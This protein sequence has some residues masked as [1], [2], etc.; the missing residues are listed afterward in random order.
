MLRKLCGYKALKNVVL[1][2][3]MWGEVS[4]DIGEAHEEELSNK[5][6]KLALDNGA[7]MVRHNNDT[8][9]THHIIR[10]IMANLP[11]VLRIQRELVDERKHIS[12]TAIGKSINQKLNEQIGQHQVE[13]EEIREEMVRALREKDDETKRRLEW[14][15]EKVRERMKESVRDSEGMAANYAAEKGRVE[16]RIRETEQEAEQVEG[17]H[18]QQLA[19]PNRYLQNVAST[20]SAGRARREQGVN[21]PWGRVN[22]L[23]AMFPPLTQHVQVLCCLAIRNG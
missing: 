13:L 6:F 14:E 1:V 9:S 5:F 2:T 10:K 7:Q 22:T 20:N 8:R 11:A 21:E 3:N 17:N 4:R 18:D 23:A 19:E 16:A 15:W 12:N